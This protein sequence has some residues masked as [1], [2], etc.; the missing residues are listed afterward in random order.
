MDPHGDSEPTSRSSAGDR[1]GPR[2]RRAGRT[3]GEAR[4]ATR[5]AASRVRRWSLAAEHGPRLV[6][7]AED[8]ALHS[9]ARLA[10]EYGARRLVSVGRNRRGELPPPRN[11]P[12]VDA[13]PL[14][15]DRRARPR[16]VLLL[17]R[18]IAP[19]SIC[20]E[21]SASSSSRATSRS[22]ACRSRAEWG[23]SSKPSERRTPAR[24]V[25][26]ESRPAAARSCGAENTSRTVT[27]RWA[28]SAMLS[29]SVPLTVSS[30]PITF[31]SPEKR[32]CQ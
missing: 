11:R 32:R 24:Q 22:P 29:R 27:P 7:I 18:G 14:E 26:D 15:L 5:R 12:A 1:S 8:H 4:E 30:S 28:R 21:R 3:L 16:G 9:A 20:I 23:F 25:S 19:A 6:G 10:A 13:S 31:G 2:R 17:E